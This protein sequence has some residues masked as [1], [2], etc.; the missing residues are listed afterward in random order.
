MS[1]VVAII[2]AALGSPIILEILRKIWDSTGRRRE[3]KKQKEE[4]LKNI[5]EKYQELSDLKKEIND[6]RMSQKRT[7]LLLMLSDHPNS[8]DIPKL[9]E[10][11]VSNGG[12]SY[13]IPLLEDWFNSRNLEIPQWLTDAL[14]NQD[15]TKGE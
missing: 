7:N 14:K 2:V 10:D 4:L 15:V 6:I 9:G 13:I 8:G 5:D 12:N 1:N 3:R 11:Y